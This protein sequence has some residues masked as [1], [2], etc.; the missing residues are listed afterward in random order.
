M[1]LGG[2]RRCGRKSSGRETTGKNK[3]QGPSCA[4]GAIISSWGPSVPFT[5]IEQNKTDL[6]IKGI[7]CFRG[8][9]ITRWLLSNNYPLFWFRIKVLCNT[10]HEWQILDRSDTCER[11]G[12]KGGLGRKY[13]FSNTVPRKFGPG[14]WSAYGVSKSLVK[15]VLCLIGMGR[16][17]SL[18]CSLPGWGAAYGQ[19][20]LNPMKGW[21][22]RGSS[23][24]P[25]GFCL[26]QQ[27]IWAVH[28][29]GK[30]LL[31]LWLCLDVKKWEQEDK[32][33]LSW[34]P[35]F[36]L[37]YGAL[38]FNLAKMKK[39][40]RTELG[41]GPVWWRFGTA[42]TEK[43]NDFVPHKVSLRMET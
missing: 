14:L 4:T 24:S 8:W 31:Q 15:E 39:E 7:T 23:W 2:H 21:T 43:I 34:Q 25:Q 42:E 12:K 33:G 30:M 40:E 41:K 10:S 28:F 29:H 20:G 9:P 16:S 22:P 3:R 37:K 32:G 18:P 36:S 6:E 1:G 35:H 13:L 11:K 26:L 38:R 19:C 17:V 5:K 27:E